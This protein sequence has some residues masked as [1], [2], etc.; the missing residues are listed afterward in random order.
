MGRGKGFEAMIELSNRR[1][2]A[3]G[4][5]LAVHHPTPMVVE[6]ALGQGT[7]VARYVKRH[8]APDYVGVVKG[9]LGVAFDAK[10]CQG[11]VWAVDEEHVPSH[12]VRFLKAWSELGGAGF[13][14]VEF[15]RR[16]KVLLVPVEAFE[17]IGKASIRLEELE[18]LEGVREVGRRPGIPVDWL[19]GLGG[20]EGAVSRGGRGRR[21]AGG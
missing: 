3:L 13:F 16:G 17:R 8:R 9:G 1:Y 12:Q 4:L 18:G 20:G 14:L 19:E 10:S 2:E 6:E 21:V 15:R 5:A 11:D 7:F